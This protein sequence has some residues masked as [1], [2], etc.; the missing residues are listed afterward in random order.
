MARNSKQDEIPKVL[1][2][3]GPSTKAIRQY[4][5]FIGGHPKQL[6]EVLKEHPA[7]KSMFVEPDELDTFEKNRQIKGTAESVLY[8]KAKKILLGGNE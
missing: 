5:S 4:S 3:V 1:I 7:L 8:E 2:Y 6:E